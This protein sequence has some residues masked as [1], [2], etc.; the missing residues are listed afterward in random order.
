MK[1]RDLGNESATRLE[2]PLTRAAEILKA[3]SYANEVFLRSNYL[4][5]PDP[6]LVPCVSH[7]TVNCYLKKFLCGHWKRS[8]DYVGWE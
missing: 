4:A 2:T 1:A 8:K 7:I 3:K 5:S 6:R